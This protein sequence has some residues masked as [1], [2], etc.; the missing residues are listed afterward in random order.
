[1]MNKLEQP[2]Y[3]KISSI[4]NKIL[5]LVSA[6]LLIVM[7]LVFLVVN[8]EKNTQVL[9]EHFE[10]IADKFLQQT[11]SGISILLTAHQSSISDKE[12]E[13]QLQS[14]LNRI[15]EAD[16]I[17]QVHLYDETGLLMLKSAYGGE[18]SSTIK[19]LYGIDE[20]LKTLNKSNQYVPFIKEIRHEKLLGYV[21]IT[22]EKSYLTSELAKNN[23]DSQ[24]SY[25]LLFIVAG[26]IGFLLTRGFNRFSR[27]GYRAP[28]ILP[29]AK[30]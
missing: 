14:Y 16:F 20:S 4:Y 17:K 13:A 29:L 22:I 9:E 10:H 2:L 23:R 18:A 27:Q 5:Q 3:P 26:L 8:T 28:A 1:M 25:R 21:R 11:I 7:L 6:I 19:M 12:R 15:A 24:T 30:K